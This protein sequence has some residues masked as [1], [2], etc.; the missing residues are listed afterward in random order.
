MQTFGQRPRGRCARRRAGLG[1]ISYAWAG[2]CKQGDLGHAAPTNGYLIFIV[3]IM[4]KFQRAAEP[5][6]PAQ[7][8]AAMS[9]AG[10]TQATPMQLTQY[11]IVLHVC[12][13]CSAA[14]TS[15]VMPAP[16]HCTGVCWNHLTGFPCHSLPYGLSFAQRR[17]ADGH[18]RAWAPWSLHL[19]PL[20]PLVACGLI[21][22]DSH[23]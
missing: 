10:A 18:A 2:A 16:A 14:L 12:N 8:K 19:P 11:M 13:V 22:R 21:E 17:A 1:C 6:S 23:K 9:E 15:L 20:C 7:A 5:T 3:I 4:C